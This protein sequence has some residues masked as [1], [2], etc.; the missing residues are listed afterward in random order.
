M[1]SKEQ[2]LRDLLHYPPERCE[3]MLRAALECYSAGEFAQAE[4]ILVGLISLDGDDA[5]PVKLLASTSLLQNKHREA[6]QLYERAH[7][8]DRKDPYTLV[9]L[10][11]IKLKS[12]KLEEAVPLF[13][14]LFALDPAGEMA[15]ANR[16]RELVRE[17]YRKLAGEDE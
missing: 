16:G 15:A 11:E 5:R 4:T 13:E 17:Y 12:L 9:A 1:P 3:E 10:G 6:E 2:S 8:L 7:Q 14:A